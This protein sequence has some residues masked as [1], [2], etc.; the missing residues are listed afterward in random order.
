MTNVYNIYLD[1]H[2]CKERVVK[3]GNLLTS[4]GPGTAFEFALEIVEMIR[5]KET[6]K[7]LS[8]GMLLL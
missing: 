1:Y 7:E 2:Y 4:R 8:D 6:R 3:D 5:G